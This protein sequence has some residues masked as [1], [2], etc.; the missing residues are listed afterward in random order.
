MRFTVASYSYQHC[1]LLLLLFSLQVMPLFYDPMDYSLPGSSVHGIS[2]AK[3]WSGL[4][5]PS[6]GDLP[7]PGIEPRSSALQ[8][9]SLPPE[10]PGKP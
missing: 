7:K 3:N 5:F 8:M 9:D 2:Q 6:P 10:S 1:V 4:P